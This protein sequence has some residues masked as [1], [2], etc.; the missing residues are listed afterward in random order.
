MKYILIILLSFVSLTAFGDE[1][2]IITDIAVA[3]QTAEQTDTKLMLVFVADWCR[4]CKP[5]KDHIKQ[6]KDNI[7]EEYTICYV[8]FDNNKKL[9]QKYS[10]S[11]L[12]STILIDKEKRLI[13]KIT[14]YMNYDSYMQRIGL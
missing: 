7:T 8:N 13:Q 6:N 9:A 14:G 4:Y 2:T 5:L 11:S 3:E 12:P 10:V 1:P